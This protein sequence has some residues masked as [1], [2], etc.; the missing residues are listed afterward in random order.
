MVEGRKITKIFIDLLFHGGTN[1]VLKRSGRG[2]ESLCPCVPLSCCVR[3]V[4][5]FCEVLGAPHLKAVVRAV[6]LSGIVSVLVH[7][8]NT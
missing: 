6:D 2:V 4:S 1:L 3:S 8:R 5:C 7:V